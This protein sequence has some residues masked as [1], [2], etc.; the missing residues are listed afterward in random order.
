MRNTIPL[1]YLTDACQ[2]GFCE[3]CPQKDK[4]VWKV[5]KASS[6]CGCLCH[7]PRKKKMEEIKLRPKADTVLEIE[8]PKTAAVL[9]QRRKRKKTVPSR[10]IF[11]S[12]GK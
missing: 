4:R 10:H 11:R 8:N 1:L 6:R 3:H 7:K 5:K 9:R 12:D 2:E